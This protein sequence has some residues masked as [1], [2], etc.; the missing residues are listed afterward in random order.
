MSIIAQVFCCCGYGFNLS[1]CWIEYVDFFF[2]II[3]VLSST[4]SAP[5]VSNKIIN[6]MFMLKNQELFLTNYFVVYF[7]GKWTLITNEL[8]RRLFRQ[9][10]NLSYWWTIPSPISWN[11]SVSD[12]IR[13]WANIANGPFH[14]KTSWQNV[15]DHNIPIHQRF[16]RNVTLYF[17]SYVV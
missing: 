12:S 1:N 5:E 11:Y 8:F 7:V 6:K 10:T 3:C 17:F 14:R 9:K 15:I 4:P 16:H 2:I 13:V